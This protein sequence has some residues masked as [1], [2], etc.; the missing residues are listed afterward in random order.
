MTTQRELYTEDGES[1]S[2]EAGLGAT[3]LDPT[4]WKEGHKGTWQHKTADGVHFTLCEKKDGWSLT[5]QDPGEVEQ[6][7]Y[8]LGPYSTLEELLRDEA[9]TL[10]ARRQC[11]PR[12]GLRCLNS[13]N[14]VVLCYRRCNSDP[15]R[16]RRTAREPSAAVQECVRGVQPGKTRPPVSLALLKG[17]GTH[18]GT[19]SRTG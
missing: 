6:R 1:T 15:A 4:L 17:A 10:A 7:T 16:L 3:F 5:C 2:T 14:R 11:L 19:Q 8:E 13:I 18:T 12:R 9:D